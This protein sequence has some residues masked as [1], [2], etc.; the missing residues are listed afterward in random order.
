[1][2][3]VEA[4]PGRVG[5]DDRLRLQQEVPGL[6]EALERTGRDVQGVVARREDD[7]EGAVRRRQYGLVRD[8]PAVVD[9]HARSSDRRPVG[10]HD[11]P[12]ERLAGV[13]FNDTAT[14]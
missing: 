2:R 5:D 3:G 13:F 11:V 10:Q 9:G 1:A 12:E 4:E 6:R 7:G 8:S 14:T